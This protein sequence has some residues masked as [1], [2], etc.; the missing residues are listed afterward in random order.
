MA[1]QILARGARRS[2]APTY[3]RVDPLRSQAQV[4]DPELL[5]KMIFDTTAQGVVGDSYAGN[6]VAEAFGRGSFT[7]TGQGQGQSGTSG[8]GGY[9]A[10][11]GTGSPGAA[12]AA[13]G[14]GKGLS[15][16]GALTGNPDAATVGGLTGFAGN[17]AD[18][19][20]SQALSA[21][22]TLGANVAGVPGGAISLGR[23]AMTGDVAMAIDGA[24]SL[25]NPAFGAVNAVAGMLGLGTLGAFVD[26]VISRANGTGG[27]NG[28]GSDTGPNSAYG[29]ALSGPAAGPGL[30]NGMPGSSSVGGYSSSGPGSPGGFGGG[31]GGGG[32]PSGN[33]GGPGPGNNGGNAAGAGSSR[34]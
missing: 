24:L 9:S 32:S 23:A 12:A 34:A 5:R 15:A 18:M 27:W 30:T 22:G 4:A 17:V 16:L 20:P 3:T 33:N 19:N 11:T 7:A 28:Y 26:G 8:Q 25:A 2:A 21:F 14:I 6:S 29:G 1:T 13:R 10:G 31:R